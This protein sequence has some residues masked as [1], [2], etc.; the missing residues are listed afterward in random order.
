MRNKLWSGTKWAALAVA[1]TLPLAAIADEKNPQ[2]IYDELQI[3]SDVLAIVQNQYVEEVDSASLIE[4]ALNGAL[5]S[6]D[7]HSSY[8]APVQ[9]TEQREAVRREYGGLGIEIQSE[10]GLVRVNHAIEEGPAYAAGIRGGDLI[11]AVD[12]IDI[13]G[14]TL[15]DAVSGM[16]G[17]KGEPVTVT[18]LSPGKTSRDVV[19]VRDTVRGRAIRHRVEQG[20]GY[21]QI[22]T[23]NNDRLTDDTT[24]ALADLEKQL[25]K[26]DKLIIDLRGNR[27]GLLTESVSISG[28]FLDGGEVLSARGRDASD[29]ERYNAE[30]G[31]LYPDAKIVILMSPGSASA[32]EIV[33]GALQDRGR[34]VVLGRRSFGKGSV[35]SVIPLGPEEGALRLTTQRYYTPSGQSIQGRGIMPDLLVSGLEDKG[36]IRKRFREDSLRNF[37]SNPDDSDYEEKYEDILFPDEIFPDDEDFQLRKAVEVLKTS[38]YERLLEA[39]ENRF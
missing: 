12:G 29:N 33:A 35:Q 5:G 27:G 34:G 31:E 17:L 18:V 32:A 16:R 11:T 22:E 7:P 2:A 15:D 25:G 19:V 28:L 21:I 3:F 6:L 14:K 36:E 26:L 4:N 8:V 23:F 37:L 10:G 20:V 13:R 9:F 30:A 38:Q 39:Q 24:R 1:A